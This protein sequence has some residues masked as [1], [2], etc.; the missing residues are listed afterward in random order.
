MT[1][2]GGNLKE[3]NSNGS[4]ESEENDQASEEGKKARSNQATQ[5]AYGEDLR[6]FAKLGDSS[7]LRS[8]AV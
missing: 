1:S 8:E 3:E 7:A 4:Q 5:E 2:P 6:G